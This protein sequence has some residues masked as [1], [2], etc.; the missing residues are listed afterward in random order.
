MS[1]AL[2][3]LVSV[4]SNLWLW[5]SPASWRSSGVSCGFYAGEYLT[6]LCTFPAFGLYFFAISHGTRPTKGFLLISG[7][8]SNTPLSKHSLMTFL[9]V[10]YGRVRGSISSS[11]A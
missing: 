10:V 1:P 5:S 8:F 7:V 9:M 4:S 11:S 2:K 6:V 3:C